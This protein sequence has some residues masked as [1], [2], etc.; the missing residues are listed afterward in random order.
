MFEKQYRLWERSPCSVFIPFRRTVLAILF[1]LWLCLCPSTPTWAE[2]QE[3]RESQVNTTDGNHEETDTVIITRA[4][5]ERM[6][7]V[8]IADLLNQVSG[9]KAGDTSVTLRGST[10]VRVILD[11]R[12]INDP[13]SSTGGVKWQMVFLP[14]V[15]RIEIYKGQGG[16]TY[17]D[18]SSGGVI[19][20]TTRKTDAFHG[21]V[22]AYGGNFATYSTQFNVQGNRGPWGLGV[23][24][25]YESTNG[26]RENN[27]K[28]EKRAGGRVA[29]AVGPE[30][31]VSL[32]ADCLWEKQGQ[33]GL[34]AFPTPH[35]R[36]EDDIVSTVFVA[37]HGSLASKT[38]FN[39]ANRR[40]VDSDKKLDSALEVSKVGEDFSWRLPLGTWGT[41]KLGTGFEYARAAGDVVE[42]Q[43]EQST[44][45]FLSKEFSLKSLP[46]T[47]STGLRG[48]FY[49]QFGNAVN[50]EFKV[51]YKHNY[52]TLGFSVNRT[53]NIPTF[54]QR[55]NESSSTKPNPDLTMER[56]TNFSLSIV[57]HL[58][59]SLSMSVSVFYNLISDRITYVRGDDG[60][61]RYENFGEVTYKGVESAVGWSPLEDLNLKCS[62]TYLEA[63]DTETGLWL[64]CKPRHQ[65][66][67]DLMWSPRKDLSLAFSTTYASSQ[68]SRSDN[69]ESVP[70]YFTG[71]VRAEYRWLHGITFFTIIKNIWDV[72]YEYGDGYPAPPL[73][74]IAGIRYQF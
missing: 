14:N 50:P 23:A 67:T 54:L 35:A 43:E 48:N 2:E 61:G 24:G 58:P 62:Y 30:T 55:Y 10:K 33:A 73:T 8:K 70:G 60:I 44:W 16:V 45:V 64:A 49:S 66:T 38:Y 6:G 18:D 51:T 53:N 37:E 31:K 39:N 65:V 29:Y 9:V 46:V 20:I 7:F 71:D 41:V 3:T 57:P 68:Y 56:A 25:G 36:Q 1:L 40:N 5:I 52:G 19:V 15:D 59:A 63:K 22:E 13:T 74:W 28:E 47:F 42:L 21:N 69:K 4:E 27:D 11:G 72:D 17:G 26:F 12:P 32:T 34:P